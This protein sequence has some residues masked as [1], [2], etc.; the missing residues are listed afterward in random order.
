LKARRSKSFQL[1]LAATAV[2][3]WSCGGVAKNPSPS[4]TSISPTNRDAGQPSFTLL[5]NGRGFAPSSAVFFNG[6]PLQSIFLGTN[7]LSA[8][9][10]ASEI[11]APG[12]VTVL[13]Q[14]PSPGGG[15][16]NSATFTIN[17][18]ATPTPVLNMLS[19]STA[20]AGGNGFAL[21][22]IGANFVPQSVVI[23][24]GSGRNPTFIDSQ[25]LSVV[26]TAADSAAAGALNID[27]QN[28]SNPSGGGASQVLQLQLNN[29]L[30][31]INAI[32]PLSVAA[33]G[34]SQLLTV[35]GSG[36]VGA[37]QVLFNGS[38]RTTTFVS[39]TVVGAVLG[40]ADLSAAGTYRIEVTNPAPGGGTSLATLFS[41]N[42]AINTTTG[43]VGLPELVDLATDGTQANN[44]LGNLDTSG[45][46]VSSTGRFVAFASVSNNLIASDTNGQ[47]D[48][49]V[50]DTC[51]AVATCR[52]ATTIASTTGPGTDSGGGE[53]GN[54]DSITPV[55]DATGVNVAF[56][57]HATNLDPNFST[58]TGT[59]YQVFLHNNAVTTTG[60]S[61]SR[62][63]SVAADGVNPANADALHPAI[64]S[65]GRF[66]AFVSAASNLV[67]G[68]N[69]GGVPQVY[70]RDTCLGQT[71]TTCTPKTIL[72]SSPDI[73]APPNSATTPANLPATQPVVATSGTF[74][75]FASAATNL[76]LGVT[77]AG[78]QI[79]S[80]TTCINGL[81]TCTTATTLVSSVD[82]VTP[83]DGASIEPA[84]TIDGRFVAF[85]STAT[86]LVQ[87]ASTGVQQIFVRDTCSNLTIGACNPSISLVSVAPDNVTPGNQLSE[88]PTI[89]RNAQVVAFASL[90]TNLGAGAT[91]GFENIYA[92]NT[93][94]GATGTPTCTQSTSLRSVSAAGG[95]ANNL[96]L[97]PAVSSDGHTVAFISP[98]S[99]L[100]P[101]DT[102]NFEDIFLAATSF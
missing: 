5:I 81:T 25:D 94:A 76:I 9:V 89:G 55:I 21:R 67:A 49:F 22:L 11:L 62:L 46:S 54:L 18:V 56:A 77:P 15:T 48:I 53:Q 23:V 65:D 38:P 64:S 79:Y 96:S 19:P 24:N 2:M 3:L 44:G 97:H 36:M 7:Q 82:G 17:P 40:T 73:L 31:A 4:I 10:L 95:Q 20:L 52:P 45:P 70:L 90:A 6:F 29:P 98:A 32:A 30:P 41:V 88:Q 28:P 72:V 83:A 16:S 14:T 63:V 1:A 75:A 92:R 84:M 13:V 68:V 101:N 8:Q 93:C 50:R 47:G 27:V 66:V 12:N 85:A 71:I 33:G 39:G 42:G 51:F 35:N 37:T 57:S 26:I 74:V 80:R 34:N 91:N 43:A 87:A 61:N 58:L 99:N 86:Q 60:N 102:N 59:S 69:P 78:S 100:V